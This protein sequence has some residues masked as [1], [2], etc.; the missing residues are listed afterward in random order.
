MLFLPP[1]F[2]VKEQQQNY[3]KTL[4]DQSIF[5][6]SYAKINGIDVVKE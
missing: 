2:H 1:L 6:A 4:E 5:N 3:T